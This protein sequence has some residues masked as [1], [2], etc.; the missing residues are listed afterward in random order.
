LF[1]KYKRGSAIKTTLTTPKNKLINRG[2]QLKK[3][4][5]ERKAKSEIKLK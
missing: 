1:K 5:S 2:S 3:V 4:T